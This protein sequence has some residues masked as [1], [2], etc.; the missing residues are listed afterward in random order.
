MKKTSAGS[1]VSIIVLVVL[2]VL[3]GYYYFQLNRMD[4]KMNELQVTIAQDANGVASV[5]NFFN[6]NLNANNQ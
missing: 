3:F 1:L 4:K 5:V 6:A 2:V